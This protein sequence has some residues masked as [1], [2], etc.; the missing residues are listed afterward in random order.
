MAKENLFT[1]DLFEKGKKLYNECKVSSIKKQNNLHHVIV[2]DGQNY[3][4]VI[5]MNKN[6]KIMAMNCSCK[7]GKEDKKCEHEVAAFLAITRGLKRNKENTELQI[8]IPKYINNY[9]QYQVFIRNLREQLKNLLNNDDHML[10][11]QLQKLYDQCDK[12]QLDYIYRLDMDQEFKAIFSYVS[13]SQAFLDWAKESIING[14]NLNFYKEY[15]DAISKQNP[16]QVIESFIDI[17]NQIKFEHNNII[18]I[19]IFNQMKD[20]LVTYHYDLKNVLDKLQGYDDILDYQL[21]KARDHINNNEIDKAQHILD[22]I[23]ENY[24]EIYNIEEYEK[25]QSLAYYQSKDIEN[26]ENYVLEYMKDKDHQKD[27]DCI[28]KLRE[29]YDKEWK[30]HRTVFYNQL[31]TYMSITAFNYILN[32][33]NE[34]EYMS[35]LIVKAPSFKIFEKFKSKIKSNNKNMYF[36]L[37]A[38]CLY[39]EVSSYK[40]IYDYD[41][42]YDHINTLRKQ[43]CDEKTIRNILLTLQHKCIEHK[44]VINVF[45]ACLKGSDQ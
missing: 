40:S 18:V 14:K 33:M 26:Y 10:L 16:Q 1:P 2:K 21:L 17:L 34:W 8:K 12:I 35:Y 38:L 9:N 11:L 28:M 39:E 32:R 31:S 36:Y 20:F 22:T 5:A 6:K 42:I 30:V 13:S 7:Q 43:S 27:I 29:L 3:H 4:V 45:K 25:V 19:Q 23:K 15:I 24:D 37:Y 44:R 41:A